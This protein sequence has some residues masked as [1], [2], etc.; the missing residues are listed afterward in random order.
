MQLNADIYNGLLTMVKHISPSDYSTE[1]RARLE[2]ARASDR[3][4]MSR[5]TKFKQQLP[6]L[7][8]IKA[9]REAKQAK[10]HEEWE[11]LKKTPRRNWSTENKI[12]EEIFDE[13]IAPRLSALAGKT[14]TEVQQAKDA[15]ME[16][17]FQHP[18]EMR[19]GAARNAVNE[20][21]RNSSMFGY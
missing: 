10:A 16:S 11:T 6:E 12:V 20:M 13:K 14:K 7:R 5:F 19:A 21:D 18:E 15:F 2:E 8:K 3:Q 17:I 4:I 1:G 9:E